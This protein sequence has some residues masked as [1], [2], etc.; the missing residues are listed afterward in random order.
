MDTQWPRFE[1][2]Q[3]DREGRPHRNAGSVHAADA[4][5][6]LQNARDVFV[7][8][9][10]C[11]SLWVVPAEAILAMTDQE[12]EASAPD[13]VRSADPENGTDTYFVFQKQSQRPSMT[14]VVHTGD[15]EAA[16]HIEAL[17][18]AREKFGVGTTYV[19]WVCPEAAIVRS[20]EDDVDSLFTPA[21]T[22]TYRMP[23]EYRVI[24]EMLE[25][26]GEMAKNQEEK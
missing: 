19:W 15:V 25:L 10:I 7:R 21:G 22:K 13:H 1:V 17:H 23:R 8:R 18:R 20:K 26:K 3:Q 24:A 9:P 11:H 14:Y 6:A 2:F 4:E 12:L 16:G 5:M